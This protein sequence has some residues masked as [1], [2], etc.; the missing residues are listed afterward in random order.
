MFD[1][2]GQLVMT[3]FGIPKSIPAHS[4]YLSSLF[5]WVCIDLR[6]SEIIAKSSAY[7]AE[8][9]VRLDVASVY[10][11]FPLCSHLNRGSKNIRNR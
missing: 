5:I 2:F 10:P 9:M 4:Q 6:L 7:D 8:L 1:L 11:F 3:H